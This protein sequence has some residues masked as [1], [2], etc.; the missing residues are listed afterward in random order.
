MIIHE[1]KQGSEEWLRL[2]SGR[3]TSSNFDRIV[4]PKGKVSAQAEK[5][6]Y[7]LLAER[8]MQRPVVQYVSTW[9]DKGMQSEEEAVKY[10]EAQRDLDTV[11]I[12]FCTND[13]ET[14]GASPDRFVGDNGLL[15]IKCPREST[16][17]AYL[18]K[19]SVDAE[20]YPQCQGQLW[21]C[22]REWN[23][24][25][26]YCPGMPEALI[27]VERNRDFIEL[28]ENEVGTFSQRLEALVNVARERGY[29]KDAE[30]KVEQPFEDPFG[31]GVS[32]EDIADE[33][34]GRKK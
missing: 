10:Y 21:V 2:R 19:S 29:I 20:Y 28:L 17:C 27:R 33:I 7:E 4:T 8:I 32:A 3:P 34:M 24:I 11:K 6:M 31:L 26:S 22:E 30:G 13:A 15:E 14:I 1:C 18:M 9:M 25:M 5:Y 23:D 12:G 16:H